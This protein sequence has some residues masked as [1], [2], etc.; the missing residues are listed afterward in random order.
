MSAVK[1][2]YTLTKQMHDRFEKADV[3]DREELIYEFNQ[4]VE[5]RGQLI[6]QLDGNYTDEER[7][8]AQELLKLD[9]SLRQQADHYMSSFQQD[10]GKF[11]KQQIG[12]RKYINPYQNLRGKDGGFIDTRN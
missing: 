12:N 4:F 1:A 2:L 11:K 3:I 10:I 5:K 9:E 6:G 8:L 7:E